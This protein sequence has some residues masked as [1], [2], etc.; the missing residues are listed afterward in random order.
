MMCFE[1]MGFD[2]LLDEK[3][4]PFVLE[5]NHA[6][7]FNTDTEL[8]LK[9]KTEVIRSTLDILSLDCTRRNRMISENKKNL[10]QR[11]LNGKRVKK[12]T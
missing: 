1:L 12:N 4:K 6:P 5:V 2:I 8:D 3:F 10:K 9:V 11:L 7:S